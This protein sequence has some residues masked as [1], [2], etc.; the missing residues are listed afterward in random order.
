MESMKVLMVAKSYVVG[1]YHGKL[2][3]IARL[4]VNLTIVVPPRWGSQ[5]LE[6]REAE[7]Y[8]MRVLPCVLSGWNHFYFYRSRVGPIDAD[9]VYLEEEPWSLVTHQV[10]RACVKQ[11]KPALFF[12]WQNI[13]RGYPPP[14]QYL[15]RY[16]HR[17]AEAAIAGNQEGRDALERRG[18]AKPVCVI[19]QCGVDPQFFRKREVSDIRSAL[20]LRGR[21]AIG[22]AGR[23]LEAKGIAD[24][25][26]ALVLLPTDCVLVLV[27]SGEFEVEA[28][29]LAEELG[30]TSRLHWVPFISSL[31]MPDYMNAFDVLV[32][33]SRTTRTW[34]EQ[35]GRVLIEAMACEVPVIGSDSGE[36]PN[37][38][39]EAGL[40][41]PEGDAPA[42]AKCL[43][44]LSEDRALLGRLAA[45]GRVRV[46]ER[47]T[48]RCIAEQ[49]VEFFREVLEARTSE[50]VLM[51]A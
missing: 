28:R 35:F 45:A 51:L 15:E 40:V 33:P 2:R 26:K 24:L 49:T 17:H 4:G 44:A 18:F 39:G 38:I 47:F 8:R 22:Y 41:F 46:L 30:V 12:T 3:E 16:S 29:R 1:A 34:K 42:L 13:F 31:E 6:I 10:L 23:I 21:F 27:G 37:V 43:R 48:N 5:Q 7:E 9:L 20:G 11:R 36:I 19:P 14:F 50:P 32:L 25:I